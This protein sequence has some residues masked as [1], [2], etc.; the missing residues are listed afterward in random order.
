MNTKF[1]EMAKGLAQS[2]TRR[3]A[4]KRFGLGMLWAAVA[5]LGTRRASAQQAYMHGYCA[6]DLTPNGYAYNGYCVD[7]NTC[8]TVYDPVDC[9]IGGLAKKRQ[10]SPCGVYD[11][12]Q[13]C[14]PRLP[15]GP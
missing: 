13:K 5:S 9:P 7:P 10:T 6:Y 12:T 11:G 8:E 1:D 3:E 14:A 4:F 2:V 15:T